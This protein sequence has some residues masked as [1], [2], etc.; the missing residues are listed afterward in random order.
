M[1][2]AAFALAAIGVLAFLVGAFTDSGHDRVWQAFL[3]S[4]TAGLASADRAIA[5]DPRDGQAWQ[6]RG[7]ILA[8]LGRAEDARASYERCGTISP[9]SAEC[10][11]G[12]VW[13]D[14]MEGRCADAERDARRAVDR[15]PHLAGNLAC[16]RRSRRLRAC[17]P[18]PPW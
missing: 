16:V 8:H 15:D 12:L 13:L 17:M 5:L 14:S 2:M 4:N 9:G 10:F 6:S 3:Q 1:F 7:D 11:L 18:G